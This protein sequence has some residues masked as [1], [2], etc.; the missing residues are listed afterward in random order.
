MLSVLSGLAVIVIVELLVLNAWLSISDFAWLYIILAGVAIV[1]WAQPWN[2]SDRYRTSHSFMRLATYLV[3]SIQCAASGV[4]F[5]RTSPFFLALL[6]V[7]L[8][9][10]ELTGRSSIRRAQPFE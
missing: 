6:S 7:V 10:I 5:G 3:L 4:V 2:R 8:F 1:L 9:V